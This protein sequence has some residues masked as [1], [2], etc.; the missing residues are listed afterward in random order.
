MLCPTVLTTSM[1]PRI[2]LTTVT[3]LLSCGQHHELHTQTLPHSTGSTK[4][5]SSDQ[6]ETSHIWILYSPSAIFGRRKRKKSGCPC[7][8]WED[9]PIL[10][11]SGFISKISYFKRK[12][13][14]KKTS[15]PGLLLCVS[16][17]SSKL[18]LSGARLHPVPGDG[19][20]QVIHQLCLRAKLQDLPTALRSD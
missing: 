7:F 17:I 18:S 20:I 1:E 6:S 5:P 4:R 13:P 19:L 10:N 16:P 3:S 14:K 2:S 9:R 8:L 15:I 11:I 12:M